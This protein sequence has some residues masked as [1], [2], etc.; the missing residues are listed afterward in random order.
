MSQM[1]TKIILIVTITLLLGFGVLVVKSMEKETADLIN[2][3]H[4]KAD[5]LSSTVSSSIGWTMMSG[6]PER[7]GELLQDLRKVKG[8]DD[9]RL[10][11]PAG[12]EIYPAPGQPPLQGKMVEKVKETLIKGDVVTV[13]DNERFTLFKPLVSEERCRSCHTTGVKVLGAVSVSVPLGEMYGEIRK[14]KRMGAL[15][16]LLAILV[17]ALILALLIKKVVLT[18]VKKAV[19]VMDMM[20]REKDLTSRMPAGAQDEMGRLAR[21]YNSF[22]DSVQKVVQ[23]INRMSY[24]VGTV[25]TQIVVN[26][27]RVAEGAQVQRQAAESTS[28]AIEQMNASIREVAEVTFSLSAFTESTSSSVLEMTAS[29][30]E[31]AGSASVMSSSVDST[32]SSITQISAS[33]KEVSTS[34][35]VLTE[36]AEISVDSIR[37]IAS[38]IK[39]VELA[40]QESAKLSEKVTR[41][42]RD[43]GLGSMGRVIEGMKRIRTAVDR[44]GDV[45]DRLGGRSRQIGEILNVIDEVTD[46]TEL[47]SLNAAILASQAGERGKGFAVVADEIKD[48]AERTASS[49]QEISKMISTVQAEVAEAVV[50]MESGKSAVEEGQTTV[51]EAKRVLE[52]IV[53]SS[54]KSS[55][56]SKKI[57]NATMEQANGARDAAEAMVN[58][59]DMVKQILRASQD[60]TSGSEQIMLEA[61]KVKDVS[62]QVKTATEEQSKG[63]VQII[64]AVEDVNDQVQHI[65]SA[66]AEQKKGSE[67]IVKS[68]ERIA[69]AAQ[70]NEDLA[71]EMSLV[72]EELARHIEELKQEV[73]AFRIT[74]AGTEIIK[75]GIMP[76]ESPAQMYKKFAPLAEYLSKKVGRDVVFKLTSS[77]ADAV[78]DVGIGQTDICYMTPSTYIEAHERYGVELLAKAVRNGVPYSHT[79]VVAGEKSGVTRLEDLRGKKFA[80]GDE[81]STSSYLVPRYMLAQAGVKLSDLR[82]YKFLGHHDDVARAVLHG[83]FDAGGLRETTAHQFRDKGLRFIKVSDD[84]PEFNFCARSGLDQTL[85]DVTRAALI[86]L[87]ERGDDDLRVLRAMDKDYTGF[88][89]ARDSDYDGVREMMRTM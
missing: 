82:E 34:V 60:L 13:E 35:G 14:N 46:Q 11:G 45:V 70:D 48:L 3:T 67:E 66:T 89:N 68:I 28:G 85:V 10:F 40:A 83:D 2:A 12:D 64:K 17:V 18:P 41:D 22:I 24:Q 27:G 37:K 52:G 69:E 72:A 36:A 63:S 74:T 65:A 62:S 33:I 30:D 19:E 81:M 31:I 56:M 79:I 44:S 21:S 9:V 53:S 47:L 71:N 77:F 51:Y 73:G 58:I 59:R 15:N 55:E 8:V 5:L 49:T 39:D 43:L 1:Q 38:S 57:E 6:S 25:S 29:I 4:S 50:A 84:I 61:Y 32:V 23:R 88:M 20:E 87:G 54:A 16:A 75:L 26:S 76:L 86:A 42:A 80:F 7:A 78:R